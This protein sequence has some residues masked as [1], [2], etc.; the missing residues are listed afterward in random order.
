MSGLYR[1][2]VCRGT[3]ER[4]TLKGRKPVA[5]PE[6]R[7]E[8]KRRVDRRKHRENYARGGAAPRPPCCVQA[9]N[10]QCPQHRQWAEFAKTWKRQVRR[11][12]DDP[13]TLALLDLFYND[14]GDDSNGNPVYVRASKGFHITRS[15]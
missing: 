10:H 5:C 4:E 3:F 6:H 1:C 9:D 8:A 2:R 15:P 14:V 7:R 11:P 13:I 12:P